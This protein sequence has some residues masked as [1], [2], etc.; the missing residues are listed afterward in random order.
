VTAAFQRDGG[1]ADLILH[2][3]RVV[4]MDPAGP[5]AAAVAVRNGR[6]RLAG[7][8]DDVRATAGPATTLIDLAGRTVVPGLIDSH[9][10]LE[11]TSYSRHYWHDVRGCTPDEILDQVKSLAAASGP[12]EWLI[13]QGTFGQDMPDK[14]ALDQAAPGHPVAVRWSMHKFQLNTAALAAAAISRATVPGP[15]IRVTKDAAGNPTGLIEEGWDLLRLALPETAGLRTAM[16]ETARELFLRHGVT[17][18]N[19][20]AASTSGLDALGR[21]TAGQQVLPS[22]GVALTARPGHQSLISTEDFAQAG[23]RSGFGSPELSLR[24][25]KIFVD[26]G[27]DGALRS[28][29][30]SGPASG[31]G[32]LT[33]APQALAQE[34]ARAVEAGLAVWIHAIG[35]L[36]QEAAVT[37]IENVAIAYPGLEHRC[38]IEHFGN[39]MYEPARLGRLI[40]AGGIPAPNPSFITAEPDDPARRQPPGVVKYGLRALLAAGAR[41]PG[42]SDTAG[43][44]PFS[45]NPWYTMHCMVN[46]ENKSGL[47]IDPGQALTV[48][49]A[50][51]S[52]TVDAAY[53]CGLEADRGSL[54]PGKRADLAVLTE[55]PFAVPA[56]RLQEVTSVLTLVGG[57]IGWGE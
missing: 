35:D 32:L 11:L 54:E 30:M 39:E 27:R 14:A 31:W 26:G 48:G 3:G 24:A 10:H 37:A 42:N 4:T 50:L 45:C 44:Q 20:I 12:G 56:A 53:G 51:R 33:R 15:G 38:R 23:L 19:E 34:V 46:R 57:R 22:F 49:E 6:I 13:F 8:E 9:T 40:A 36:A 18:I 25:V 17:T 2:G 1:P 43:A 28:S 55:D 7:R 5:V 41:P 29:L 47:L 16:S 52:F 21:M